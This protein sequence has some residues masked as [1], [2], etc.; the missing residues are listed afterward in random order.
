MPSSRRPPPLAPDL[1]DLLVEQAREV[2]ARLIDRYVPVRA[3]LAVPVEVPAPPPDPHSILGLRPGCAPDD[4]R[5]RVRELARIFHP[6]RA[7]GHAEKMMEVNAAA[8][9]ILKRPAQ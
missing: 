1:R 3:P 5:R 4:V 8:D 2:I 9:A 7:G 6:D